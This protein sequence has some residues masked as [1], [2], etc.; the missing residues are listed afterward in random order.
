MR[1]RITNPQ[2][3]WAGLMF[4][5]FGILAIVVARDYPMGSAM[6]MGP[7]YFPTYIGVCLIALG[8]VITLLG[9]KTAGDRVGA[10]AFRSM[11]LLGAAFILF[12]WAI[13]HVGFV[14][15]L[16]AMIVLSSL[17]G[18]EFKLKEVAILSLF[19]IAGSWAL[20][21]WGLELPFPL[22]WR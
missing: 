17:A 10:F 15:A 13:D 22:F 21:I 2:D 3:F 20:F 7:G 5:A 11:L 8:S 9:L 18:A 19:L 1:M 12:G 6:R 4:I 14:I 16:L